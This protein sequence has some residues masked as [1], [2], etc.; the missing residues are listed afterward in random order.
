MNIDLMS[1]TNVRLLKEAAHQEL[2][3]INNV[4]WKGAYNSLIE[5]LDRLDDMI[6]KSTER[7]NDD[8]ISQDESER[9]LDAA[10][11][12]IANSYGGD[13]DL[14]SEASGWKNAAEA[15]RDDYH[16]LLPNRLTQ[17]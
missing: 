8:S 4:S 6:V 5:A 17:E 7:P 10:W 2:S 12:I 11:G 15:W 13:W 1:C 14:A 9:L 3:E 16:N